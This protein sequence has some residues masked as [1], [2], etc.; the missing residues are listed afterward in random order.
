MN[1]LETSKPYRVVVRMMNSFFPK[2]LAKLRF[3]KLFG[4]KLDLTNPKDLNEKILWLSLCSDTSRW[5]QLSDK[6]AVREYVESKGYGETLVKL[7]GKWDNPD[8]IDW[9]QLPNQF[10]LKTNNGCG[11]VLIV[12][13]KRELDVDKTINLLKKWMSQDISRET[14]EFHYRNIKPCI[15]A[16]ELLVPSDKDR[17][18]STS[19]IDYKIWCFNGKVDSFLL[20]SNRRD[21]G[22]DLSVY[23][24]DWEYHPEYSV[25][26]TVHTERDSLVPR[27]SQLDEMILIAEKLSDGFPEM[28]VDLYVNNDKIYFGELTFTSFGGTMTYYTPDCLMRMGEKIDLSKVKKIG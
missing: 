3:R 12:E 25:F 24:T 8:L 15:I 18:L 22:C 13:N 4:R 7:Y 2:T 26:D 21:D 28:R 9:N 1:K 27:P 5:S 11:T 20:C 17:K 23:D 19:I 10:V 6:Y 14:A 16:E